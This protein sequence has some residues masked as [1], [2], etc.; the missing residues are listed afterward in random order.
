MLFAKPLA[1]FV[2]LPGRVPTERVHVT[3]SLW[4]VYLSLRPTFRGW[5]L[6]AQEVGWVSWASH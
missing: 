1:S 6:Q 5:T 3:P 4:G 2:L